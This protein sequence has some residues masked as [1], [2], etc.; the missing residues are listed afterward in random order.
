MVQFEYMLI[1]GIRGRSFKGLCLNIIL[2][3]LSMTETKDLEVVK[4]QEKGASLVEYALLVGLIAVVCIVGITLVGRR[5][6]SHFST[7]A[8]N[9]G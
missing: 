9:L 8:K 4:E 1:A 5:A 3:E 7:I 6:S 2:E